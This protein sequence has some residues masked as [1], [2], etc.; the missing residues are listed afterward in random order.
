MADSCP[1]CGRHG[2]GA[3][4]CPLCGVRR[5]GDEGGSAAAGPASDGAADSSAYA[6]G[7][8]RSSVQLADCE[9]LR[10]QVLLYLDNGNADEAWKCCRQAVKSG[11]MGDTELAMLEKA[12]SELR[13]EG[14]LWARRPFLTHFSQAGLENSD[15]VRERISLYAKRFE[16]VLAKRR[17]DKLELERHK[18]AW[19]ELLSCRERYGEALRLAE[20]AD[21]SD[22]Y[23][24]AADMFE[25]AGN[26]SNARELRRYCIDCAVRFK[27]IAAA[28]RR[29]FWI[30]CAAYL[31]RG[32]N[33]I[34]LAVLA[35][36]AAAIIIIINYQNK[37]G[38]LLR[39]DNYISKGQYVKAAEVYELY[40]NY[41]ACQHLAQVLQSEGK[42]KDAIIIAEKAANIA[43][44]CRKKKSDPFY[45]DQEY[46][47]V[48]TCLAM[49]CQE[50]SQEAVEAYKR[51]RPKHPDVFKQSMDYDLRHMVAGA[52][53]NSG[54]FS[55]ASYL[56]LPGDLLPFGRY[57][58]DGN[59][60]NGAEDIYWVIKGVSFDN[61]GVRLKLVSL[62]AL[63]IMPYNS[64]KTP[65][66]WKTCSLRHWLNRTFFEQ[67]FNEHEQAAVAA[68]SL[69]GEKNSSGA[70]APWLDTLDKV[71]VMSV[72]E[73]SSLFKNNGERL[74]LASK[75]A[76]GKDG[77][78]GTQ[79]INSFV[80]YYGRGDVFKERTGVRYWLRT[81]G[82]NGLKAAIAGRNG[83]ICYGK[84][85]KK[86]I[87][88]RVVT[89]NL[90]VRPVMRI[91][92]SKSFL[93]P[94]SRQFGAK[95]AGQMLNDLKFN[96]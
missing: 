74:S 32:T 25:E 66:T 42:A 23:Y 62:V 65:V 53:I 33:L 81:P 17:K 80:G 37:S 64:V 30:R 24:R 49:A 28:R 1:V 29:Q 94:V 61:S 3:L 7:G 54:R 83:G 8:S 84:A 19:R 20:S 72:D 63:D 16:N 13:H 71:W 46:D 22:D 78:F 9:A 91:T 47:A 68:T 48:K 40:D 56:M 79:Q 34:I 59:S 10:R 69:Q 39:A 18:A 57:E 15:I 67:A 90:A 60:A 43:K 96:K 70:S 55:E 5:R 44:A 52:L 89:D 6:A 77:D 58:Q 92:C 12:L 27:E 75:Y 51:L 4:Y 38:R 14:V 93:P 31:K 76:F 26:Y 21:S 88:D 36:A 2:A 45:A 86:Q 85:Q 41:S 87:Y 50:G 73:A 95:T 11:N 35:V 82:T